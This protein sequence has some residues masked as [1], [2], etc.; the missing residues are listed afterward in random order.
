MVQAFLALSA[1]LLLLVLLVPVVTVLDPADR[2]ARGLTFAGP[3]SGT[4]RRDGGE[5]GSVS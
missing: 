5:L 1:A 2:S 3:I 4:D